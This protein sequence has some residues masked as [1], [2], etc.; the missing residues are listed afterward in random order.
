MDQQTFQNLVAGLRANDAAAFD[1]LVQTFGAQLSRAARMYLTDPRLRR[2]LDTG[3]I[4]QEVLANFAHRVANGEF[5]LD[6]PENLVSLLRKMVRNRV[7][8]HLRRDKARGHDQQ[9]FGMLDAVPSRGRSPAS[10]V[11]NRDLLEKVLRMLPER[12]R[13]LAMRRAEGREWKEVADELGE[14]PEALRRRLSRALNRVLEDLG[15]EGRGLRRSLS[16]DLG[17]MLSDPCEEPRVPQALGA[18]ES[19]A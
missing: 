13:P 9:V 3:D 16:Q 12:E 6:R 7:F 15:E 2:V 1:R 11:A 14:S 4:S 8:D 19:H 18:E 17:R 10:V 5:D